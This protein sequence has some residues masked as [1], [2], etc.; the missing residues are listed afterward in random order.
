MTPVM[1]RGKPLLQL[2]KHV[3]T[4]DLN[5]KPFRAANIRRNGLATLQLNRP[6]VQ[7][8]RDA[9]AE[10]DTLRQRTA[11]MRALVQQRKHHIFTVA[12]H[13]DVA[14]LFNA[15]FEKTR[16]QH[17]HLVQLAGKSPTH[18]CLYRTHD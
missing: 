5:R 13:G 2:D 8:A 10:H 1:S 3:A 14:A 4:F 17:R 16:T 18:F 6:V 15:T 12:E 9:L 7:W 11:L